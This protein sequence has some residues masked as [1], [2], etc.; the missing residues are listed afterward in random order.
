MCYN[1]LVFDCPNRSPEVDKLKK[2]N[3]VNLIRY[4]AESNDA[5]F[6]NEAYEIARGFD[7]MGDHQLAE[8][9]MAALSD[10]NTFIP[11]SNVIDSAFFTKAELE[12]ESLPIPEA[13]ADDIKG[14]INAVGHNAGI[15][16]FLFEGA[17]G[18]GKTV[19]AKQVARLLSRELFIVDFS[20]VVDS[21]LG[22]T[23]K[24][25]ASLFSEINRFVRPE[26]AMV[27]FDEIDALALDRTS[28]GDIREMGRA[29]SAVFKGFDGLNKNVVLIATTNLFK[30]FD[31]AL[32]RRFDSII[33]FDRYS[34]E[35]LIVVAEA[36][37]NRY[38][39]MFKFAGRDM[40]LFRKIIR[41][42]PSIPYPG[43]LE[44]L[45][46]TSL[47]FSNP[48]E[49]FDYLRRL[50]YSQKTTVSDD[51]AKLQALGFT[52]REIEVLSKRSKSSVARELK[53]RT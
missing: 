45:I 4:Y 50:L 31:K 35:D 26:K 41:L 37:L 20:N 39:G 18:T 23:A 24:N 11:Q 51:V 38:L 7:A 10:A 52:V 22:Q 21:R 30:E 48:Q 28:S 1:T 25:I 33:S 53:E 12:N 46:K 14:L 2:K 29:T 49:E 9:I 27:L 19:T 44:N 43:E 17:P 36:L 13:I 32:K 3:V 6:R 34:Q 5:G 42:M 40:R 15:N 16:K 47:A 8:Y